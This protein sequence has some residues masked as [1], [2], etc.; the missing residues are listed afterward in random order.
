MVTK[1]RDVPNG[2]VE[3]NVDIERLQADRILQGGRRIGRSGYDIYVFREE[4]FIT[5]QLALTDI[6]AHF[7]HRELGWNEDTTRGIYTNG[8]RVEDPTKDSEIPSVMLFGKGDLLVGVTAARLLYIETHVAGEV[9]VLYQILRAFEP[10]HRNEGMGTEALELTVSYHPK[11]RRFAHRTGSPIAAWSVIKSG[12]CVPGTLR[13]WDRFYDEEDGGEGL[14]E[15]RIMV[16]LFMATAIRGRGVDWSTGVSKNDYP[17][18]NVSYLP[19]SGHEPTKALLERMT[20]RRIVRGH[21]LGMEIPGRDSVYVIGK[22]P[23]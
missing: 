19:K 11:A 6:V 1:E 7:A 3:V 4:A 16:G 22:L 21:Q 2:I 9:P 12:I 5:N 18:P 23:T 8:L 10:E 13:P 20:G 14:L 17:E 15:Q